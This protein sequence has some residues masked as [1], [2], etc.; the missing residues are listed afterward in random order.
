MD[1]LKKE[2]NTIRVPSR[3]SRVRN[4]TP[5]NVLRYLSGKIGFRVERLKGL[6][7]ASIPNIPEIELYKP[8][9][10]PWLGSKSFRRYFDIAAPNTL[11]SADRCYVLFTLMRQAVHVEGD[12]WECGVYKGGTAAMMAAALQDLAP[13]KSLYLFDTFEGMP[14]TDAGKDLHQKGD[15]GDTSLRAVRSFVGHESTVVYRKGTIP[16]SFLGLESCQVAMA[17]ID[18][19]IYRSV[20]DCLHFIWPR[21]SLGGFVVLDDY[22][23]PTCPGAR[24]AVD[25]FFQT[26]KCVP[27]CLPTGQAVVFKSLPDLTNTIPLD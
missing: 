3:F 21:V 5:K 13:S 8:L 26:Q 7:N 16:D 6:R 20:L 10:S 17:H 9:Y 2:V 14:D 22:G 1:T 15:F 19:D 24:A 18:V 23:F 27:L 11:V 4:Y 12:I 25:D